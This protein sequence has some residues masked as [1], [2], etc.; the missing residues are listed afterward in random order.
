MK[1]T[2]DITKLLNEGEFEGNII[3]LLRTHAK[4]RQ[5]SMF[6]QNY[7]IQTYYHAEKLYDQ[8][9]IKD[10]IAMLHIWA[11]TEKADHGFLRMLMKKISHNKI[12]ELTNEYS[13]DKRELS[14]INYAISKHNNIKDEVKGIVNPIMKVKGNNAE[15]LVWNLLKKAKFYRQNNKIESL[16]KKLGFWGFF[17]FSGDDT[18][19]SQ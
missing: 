17:K 8:T 13:S 7:G 6:L 4:C 9:V 12:A 10:L 19:D 16:K 18:N 15:E 5:V 11:N 1:L 3:V 2:D 14:L